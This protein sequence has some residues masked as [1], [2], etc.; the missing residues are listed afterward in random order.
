M[1]KK[2]L[3][4]GGSGYVGSNLIFNLIKNYHVIN[5]DLNLFGSRH[6]P[7]KNKNF[8]MVKGDIR[9]MR[10]IKETLKKFDPKQFIHLAC[11]S[12]D[13]SFLLNKSLSKEVN[14]TAFKNLINFSFRKL[15]LRQ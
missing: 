7:Y 12:N 4:F 14:L 3:I 6:L 8:T 15:L 5:Y 13:P 2:I 11:I 9:D 10:K 1:K